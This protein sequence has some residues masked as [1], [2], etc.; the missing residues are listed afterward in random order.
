[1]LNNISRTTGEC[2]SIKDTIVRTKATLGNTKD[3]FMGGDALGDIVRSEE[4]ERDIHRAVESFEELR[5][6]EKVRFY[7]ALLRYGKKVFANE[8]DK[9]RLLAILS[10][11]LIKRGCELLAFAL[12]DDELIMLLCA[13]EGD[14]GSIPG[15][16]NE[17]RSEYRKYGACFIENGSLT[18]TGSTMKESSGWEPV[19]EN[20]VAAC[21]NYIHREP[22]QQGYVRDVRDFWWSSYISY[23]GRYEWHFLNILRCLSRISSSPEKALKTLQRSHLKDRRDS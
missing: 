13:P 14:P 2:G 11:C 20:E 22:K 9:R 7:K 19:D 6:Q 15:M 18:E 17:I 12:M 1:M 23:M 10:T 5:G 16:L 21:C 4:W 3:T 8:V